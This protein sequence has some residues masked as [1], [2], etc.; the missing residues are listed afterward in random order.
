VNRVGYIAV[1]LRHWQN[2]C[3]WQKNVNRKSE[4]GNTR[5]DWR[6]FSHKFPSNDGIW[7]HF[8]AMLR[9]IRLMQERSA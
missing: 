9:Q 4:K 7:V 6:N 8:I 2:K 1:K 5:G 3:K